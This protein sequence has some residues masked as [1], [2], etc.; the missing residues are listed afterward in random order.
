L[1]ALPYIITVK[2]RV[3]KV[4]KPYL[5]L[6]GYTKEQLLGRTVGDVLQQLLRISADINKIRHLK[7]CNCYMFDICRRVKDVTISY[8]ENP[9]LKQCIYTFRTKKNSVLEDKYPFLELANSANDMGMAL[10]SVP[11]FVLLKGNESYRRYCRRLYGSSE[12]IIGKRVEEIIPD[13]EG[14]STK[15][16]FSKVVSTCK[17]MFCDENMKEYP[18]ADIVCTRYTLTPIIEEDRVRYLV[19]IH[20]DV[21]EKVKI[22]S[23]LSDKNSIME[24]QK[25]YFEK[26][27]DYLYNLFNTMRL[28]IISFS[29]P[30][31]YIKEF[32]K[33]ALSEIRE[34]TGID[35]L[36]I[37]SDTIGKRLAEL[38]PSINLR[39]EE[40]YIEQMNKT[41]SSVCHKRIG[42]EKKGRKVY[43][44]II[45]H[46]FIG[47]NEE[48]TEVLIVGVDVTDEVEKEKQMENI[49]K[50]KDDFLYFITHEFKTPLTVINAA[51]QTLEHIYSKEIPDKA[52][53]LI[54]KIKQNSFRQL[55][56]VNNLLEIARINS[57]FIKLKQRNVDIVFLT[58][59]ITESV[60][61]YAQQKGVGIVFVSKFPERIIGLDD[62]KFERILLN[63]LSNAIKFTP[64]GRKVSVEVFSKL[65]NNKRMVCIKV[66]DQG[67][68]IPKV[69]QSLIFDQFGQ[70]DSMLTNQAEGSG[71]GLY[72]VK[73]LVNS[74]GG[75]ITLDSELGKGSVFTLMIPARKVKEDTKEPEYKHISDSRLVQSLAIEF[76]DIYI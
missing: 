17:P 13:W 41:K 49:L 29:F 21:T 63:L 57:G 14:S 8:A 24:G 35:N 67:I 16:I 23:T 60:A 54:G 59:S 32:N 36:I 65:H 70:V 62:E 37:K 68:G 66:K 64:A 51:V 46:P 18:G 25:N 3:E 12:D 4:N 47:I 20:N 27:R 45:Y 26:Q 38:I 40:I 50:L 22:R 5:D 58:K 73:L 56:L 48:I 28:P 74:I 71:I 30:E 69:K 53:V 15:N 72:L 19:L 1:N 39:N 33:K 75:D 34:F 61:I 11:D 52:R 2:N 76:S 10:Y 9:E 31:Y 44:D 6:T 7:K 55:R 42:M 43:Y